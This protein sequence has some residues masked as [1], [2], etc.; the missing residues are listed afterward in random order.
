MSENF[1]KEKNKKKTV[2]FKAAMGNIICEKETGY[3]N[4]NNNINKIIML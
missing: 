4:D 2:S 1:P 3:E